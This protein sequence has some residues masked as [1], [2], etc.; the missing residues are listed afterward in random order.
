MKKERSKTMNKK[1]NRI[2][3]F[4]FSLVVVLPCCSWTKGER[5]YRKQERITMPPFDGVVGENKIQSRSVGS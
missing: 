2:Y 4:V 3:H 1:T 5:Y